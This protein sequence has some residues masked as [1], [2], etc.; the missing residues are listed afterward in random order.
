MKASFNNIGKI[1]GGLV[2][3][4]G[5]AVDNKGQL[6]PNASVTIVG[7]KESGLLDLECGQVYDLAFTPA[8]PLPVKAE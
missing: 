2:A 1:N 8:T 6:I 7:G 4:Y 5:T 3:A